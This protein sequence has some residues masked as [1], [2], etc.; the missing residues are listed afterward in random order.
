MYYIYLKDCEDSQSLR[1]WWLSVSDDPGWMP[2]E[3]GCFTACSDE[4]E[5][6]MLL[7]LNT[8]VVFGETVAMLERQASCRK[9]CG[10]TYGNAWHMG[11][12]IMGDGVLCQNGKGAIESH[13]GT[14][15]RMLVP[16]EWRWMGLS[17]MPERQASNRN[18]VRVRWG[19]VLRRKTCKK[20]ENRRVNACCT[21]MGCV[22]RC[23]IPEG[24]ARH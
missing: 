10:N 24:Q 17:A 6:G 8:G 23:A 5:D 21:G 20:C 22:G 7:R 1:Y 11:M 18:G 16:W 4:D 9:E 13:A 19:C 12:M 14:P 15:V 3:T 2:L